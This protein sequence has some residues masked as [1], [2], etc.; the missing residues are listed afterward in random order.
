MVV[1]RRRKDDRQ[2]GAIGLIK[3][4]TGRFEVERHEGTRRIERA[5]RQVFGGKLPLHQ[6]AP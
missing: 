6:A 4:E 2:R 5:L 1:S 3:R